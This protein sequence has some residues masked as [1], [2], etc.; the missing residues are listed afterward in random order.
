MHSYRLMDSRWWVFHYRRTTVRGAGMPF[1][2]DK[3]IMMRDFETETEAARYVNYLNGG[4]Y[5]NVETS[6]G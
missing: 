6:H 1:S 2:E 3:M 4:P 5:L